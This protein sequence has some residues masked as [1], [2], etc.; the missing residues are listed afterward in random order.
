MKAW[1]EHYNAVCPHSGIGERPPLSRLPGG[2]NL[3][4]L[5]LVHS[6]GLARK[7][8]NIFLRDTLYL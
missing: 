8:P 4:L 6:W 7:R 2:N 5:M 3:M 1:L